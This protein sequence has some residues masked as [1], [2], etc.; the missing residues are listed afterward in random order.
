MFLFKFLFTSLAPTYSSIHKTFLLITSIK[1]NRF[2][3]QIEEKPILG[4]VQ[5]PTTFLSP[6]SYKLIAEYAQA[7]DRNQNTS[8]F[9]IKIE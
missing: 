2:V 8:L 7:L 3:F 5:G 4:F 1:W 6:S 9:P